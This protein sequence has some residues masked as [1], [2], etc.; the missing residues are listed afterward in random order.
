VQI[1]QN[2][3]TGQVL[4]QGD[5]YA[6]DTQRAPGSTWVRLGNPSKVTITVNG[7]P[8]SP[9]SLVAGQPYNVQFE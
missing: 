3:P 8:L 4:F 2:G 6:G 1:R 9:P 5:L 7:V